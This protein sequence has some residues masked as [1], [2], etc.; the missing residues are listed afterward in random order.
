MVPG[1][2]EGQRFIQDLAD[3]VACLPRFIVHENH[4]RDRT[5]TCRIV[6]AVFQLA[7]PS[8]RPSD[9]RLAVD[10]EIDAIDHPAGITAGGYVDRPLG[11][12][13]SAFR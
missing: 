4:E 9:W 10:D 8:G 1:S 6:S 11:E 12:A 7:D 13:I 5:V 2:D 3:V